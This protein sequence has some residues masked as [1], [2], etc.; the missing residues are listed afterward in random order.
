MEVV[1]ADVNH[2]RMAAHFVKRLELRR[3]YRH[4]G[5]ALSIHIKTRQITLVA[6]VIPRIGMVARLFRVPMSAG[7][8]AKTLFGQTAVRIG[9]NVKAVQTRRKILQLRIEGQPIGI[10]DNHNIAD[11]FCT[12]L[13]EELNGHDDLFGFS[14]RIVELGL[15]CGNGRQSNSS[16]EHGAGKHRKSF[17]KALQ[18]GGSE[19][20]ENPLFRCSCKLAY[21]YCKT[22]SNSIC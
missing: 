9:V 17:H 1:A 14:H 19:P 21:R 18:K 22:I 10:L 5:Y 7:L 3:Q 16:G 8:H 15:V 12:V 13:A 11:R 6:L 4:I 20:E 2:Q